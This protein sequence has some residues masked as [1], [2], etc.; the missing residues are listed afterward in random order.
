M[1]ARDWLI[2]VAKLKVAIV[3]AV[4][5]TA[6]AARLHA[7]DTALWRYSAERFVGKSPLVMVEGRLSI[8]LLQEISFYRVSPLGHLIVSMK[9]K[10]VAL[11]PET[12]VPAWIRDDIKGLA[13]GD[14]KIIPLMPLAL[15]PSANGIGWIDLATGRNLWNST[16]AALVGV[17]WYVMVPQQRLLLLFG[18]SLESLSSLVAVDIVTGEVR[19]RHDN[20]LS[21]SSRLY[22]LGQQSGEELSDPGHQ[23]P[24]VDTD[25]TLILY[26]S[27]DGP[28]KL[29]SRTGRLIWRTDALAGKFPPL[30]SQG[31]ALMLY[32]DGVLF[33]PY[34]KRLLAV[35]TSDGSIIWDRQEEFRSRLVQME[36]TPRGLLVRGRKPAHSRRAAKD[37][38]LDL[39]EPETGTSI[40]QEPVRS[41]NT[42]TPF[43]VRGDTIYITK[44][45]EF[46]A[47]DF[48]DGSAQQLA[49]FKFEDGEQPEMVEAIGED[50]LLYSSQNFLLLDGV[51]TVQYERYYRGPGYSFLEALAAVAVR[52]AIGGVMG[53]QDWDVRF[54]RSRFRASVDAAHYAYVY[55]DQ[56]L[57]ERKGNSLV[58]LDKTNG[59][60]TGRVWLDLREPELV[61]DSI[62]GMV[63]VKES[64]TEIS[65]HQFP[66]LTDVPLV[67]RDAGPGAPISRDSL[68][69]IAE[70]REDVERPI[71]RVVAVTSFFEADTQRHGSGV[72]VAQEQDEAYVAVP[73]HLVRGGPDGATVVGVH[74]QFADGEAYPATVVDSMDEAMALAVLRVDDVELQEIPSNNGDPRQLAIGAVTYLMEYRIDGADG[75]LVEAG[76]LS[77]R[78]GLFIEVSVAGS[79][80]PAPRIP[81]GSN[82]RFNAAA[83]IATAV[84]PHDPAKVYAGSQAVHQSTDKGQTWVEISPDLTLGRGAIS[85]IAPS[86]VD[87][88]VIW[89]GSDDGLIQITRRGG[90]I[91]TRVTPRG[92]EGSQVVHI[93]ASPTDAGTAL[94]FFRDADQPNAILRMM[95][96]STFGREWEQVEPG[97]LHSSREG[98]GVVGGGLF[99]S[100]RQLIGLVISRDE[101]KITAVRIDVVLEWLRAWSYLPSSGK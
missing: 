5:L 94:A 63:F 47:V 60:E 89:A 80:H 57:G 14:F 26:V 56:P 74:V 88:R 49:K 79:S 31:Y 45:R 27:K 22:P 24:I 64:A 41:L 2:R 59:E 28:V 37:F 38:F 97:D 53:P 98:S 34:E 33:V 52:M 3:L 44:K 4:V 86:P 92:R 30:L 66:P 78:D 39:L 58:R 82:L 90:R 21:F 7:Q 42:D 13:G 48:E 1:L 84:A 10:L 81:R 73:L 96:T 71:Q 25:T 95:A 70:A 87:P 6:P 54:L 12:G 51:G 9:D 46:V 11:D 91:W 35:N 17:Y 16:A 15:V 69:I 32:H 68:P 75:E 83:G 93:Q 99:D 23:P 72:W 77:S 20:L 29:H 62:S 76:T 55:T 61:L 8:A 19:W 43:V 65:A 85:T 100:N 67:D 50:F 36:L 18:E 101:Q 40:W